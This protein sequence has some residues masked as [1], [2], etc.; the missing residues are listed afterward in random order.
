M[1]VRYVASG[2]AWGRPFE[3]TRVRM[4]AFGCLSN[5]PSCFCR[6]VHVSGRGQHTPRAR[7]VPCP[8]CDLS[9]FGRAGSWSA[10]CSGFALR[11]VILHII[12]YVYGTSRR[13]IH[14]GGVSVTLSTYCRPWGD[15]RVIWFLLEI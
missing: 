14:V 13:I 5:W 2:G 6:G 8:C 4:A 10:P 7:R 11:G 1:C 15:G 9:A 3:P 12:R